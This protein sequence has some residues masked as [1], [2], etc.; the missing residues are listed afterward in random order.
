MKPGTPPTPYTSLQ[1]LLNLL[2]AR[3]SI[4]V[5]SATDFRNAVKC[6]DTEVTTIAKSMSHSIST[7]KR[8]YQDLPATETAAKAY[9]ARSRLM[10]DTS[11]PEEEPQQISK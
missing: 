7:H 6:T 5:P 2:E 3:Y 9:K 10:E 4:K 8:Y 11:S 1:P